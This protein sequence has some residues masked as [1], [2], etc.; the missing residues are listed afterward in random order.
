MKALP[1]AHRPP[2]LLL[3]ALLGLGACESHPPPGP[4]TNHAP[5]VHIV[6]PQVD[7]LVRAGRPVELTA[8]VSDA[9]D[10]DT[11]EARVLWVSSVS[12]QLASGAHASATLMAPG[13]HTLTAT[14]V[15]SGGLSSS[16][17]ITVRVLEHEAPSVTVHAPAAGSAFNLGESF[18]L[19]CEARSASGE[20]LGPS[21]VRW[22]SELSG[23]LASADVAR[24]AL[25]VPGEDTLTCVATDPATGESA[26][27]TVSVTVRSNKAPA[28]LI[29][30]P[31]RTEV[32]VKSG[33]PPPLDATVSFRATAQDF[34]TPG[35]PGNLDAAITWTLEPGD[36]TLGKGPTLVHLFSTPGEFTVVARV[37]DGS[38]HAATDSVRVRLVTNLPPQC[39][40]ALPREDGA[41]LSPG[42]KLELMGRCVDPETGAALAPTWTT[43]ASLAP[44]GTDFELNAVL[45]VTGAQVLTACAVDPEDATLRGCAERPVRVV[46]NTAPSACAIEAPVSGAVL[47]AGVPV[48]LEGTALDAEDPRGEL[49]FVWSS[50]RDGMLA[51]GS[52]AL[53]RRLVSPGPHTLTLTVTDPRGLSCSAT[54]AVTVNGAPEVNI[55]MVRQGGLNC[56]DTP[57]RVGSDITAV[58][59]A[60]DVDEPGV[61]AELA[62]LDNL[63]DALVF[64]GATATLPQPS[65]GKHTVVLRATDQAGAVGRGAASFTVLGASGAKLVE[66]VVTTD[67][68]VAALT[69]SPEGLRYVDGAAATVFRVSAPATATPLDAPARALTVL[70]TDSGEVLFVG[71]EAGVARCAGNTCTRHSEGPLLFSGKKVLAVA[72]LA[73]PDLL[74]LG[75]EAGLILTRAS[76][77]SMGGAPGLLVGRRALQ[78]FSVRQ[79]ALS[80]ATS[81]PFVKAWAATPE[82]LAEVTVHVEQPFEPALASVSVV[83]HVPPE[84][85]DVD[86]LSVAV[87]P[88]GQV[89]VGTRRG[90]GALGQEGPALRASPW[91]LPDEQVQALLFERHPVTGASPVDVLWAGTRNGLVR[92]DLARDIVTPL[93]TQDGLLDADVRALAPRP[94]GGR[95]IG[96]ARGIS[97]Y[98]GN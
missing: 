64:K 37:V 3:L 19:E 52:S 57:C 67:K 69:Q 80:P 71:T 16:D 38:G 36:V 90:F 24:A 27:A 97:R 43:S 4:P 96:T 29:T 20:R 49:R 58:G 59:G 25:T 65:P 98:E 70:P 50:T 88:E 5:T 66:T 41:R 83:M 42:S 53:T 77:P 32:F 60:K 84:V 48:P 28:V 46:P 61:L 15:D 95:Y 78:G 87:G 40:I 2:P 13:E 54:V 56:L 17:A 8:T 9:E 76:N 51:G 74:L 39:D 94:E 82:G 75:T 89:Y 6:Q 92:Y 45:D 86:V 23:P 93:G 44:L 62:W 31:E 18:A 81:A 11:V 79:L 7:T 30:R 68:P 63:G 14:V 72:A 21:E 91:N 26:S 22:T 10:G 12:G 73:T 55:S 1:P 35:G 33:A 34:D 85:P 47:N